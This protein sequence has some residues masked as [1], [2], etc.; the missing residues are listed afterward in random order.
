MGLHRVT[1]PAAPVFTLE[2]ARAHLRV[3]LIDPVAEGPDDSLIE[4]FIQ[5]ATDEIDGRDGWLGRALITQTWRLYLDGFPAG[6][7]SLPLP[8]LQSVD[9][10]K[11]LDAEGTQVTLS[12]SAY[13]VSPF[14]DPGYVE[15][16]YNTAWPSTL[17]VSDA[18]EITFTAGY[19]ASGASVPG[20]IRQYLR[21]R[22]GQFYEHR[23]AVIAGT[24][25]SEVPHVRSSLESIR[26]RGGLT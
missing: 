9:S 25:V 2:E 3:D 4:D 17:P 7:I 21:H 1:A 20:V 24:I 14:K 13:R 22:V 15:P 16:V 11:Y 5:A 19:G 6:R 23:E 8:P 26:Y 12:P 18:V 10:I